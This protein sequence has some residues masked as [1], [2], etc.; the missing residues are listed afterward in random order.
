MRTGE[1]I[2]GR[3]RLKEIAGTGGMGEVWR[4]VDEQECRDVALKRAARGADADSERTH[5]QLQREARNA[6]KLNHPHIV[7]FLDEVIEG[8]ERWLVMEYVPSQSLAQILDQV[9]ALTPPQV[10]Y[11]GAQIASA[12][13]AVHARGIQ[14]R[15]V[16]PGNILVTRGGIAKLTDFGISRSICGD[17]TTESGVVG[18]TVAF[19]ASEVA[20]GDEPTPESDVF[21]L[22]A[23]LFAAVEGTPPF[24]N[25]ENGWRTLRL[26]AEYKLLPT[27]RA[28]PLTPVLSALLQRDPA[29]RPNAAAARE[30]L[31]EL[32]TT[33]TGDGCPLPW[34]VENQ[35]RSW[36][37]RRRALAA[38]VLCLAAP[39]IM[40]GDVVSRSDHPGPA[41]SQPMAFDPR[42]ADPC[43]LTDTAVLARFGPATQEPALG[44][45]NRC[46][47]IV[48]SAKDT[49]VGV[50]VELEPLT[51]PSIGGSRQPAKDGSCVQT[52]QSP[53]PNRI[54]N[55]A[56]IT[57][58]LKS[59][60]R[61][62]NLCA[63]ADAA[64]RYAD[65]VLRRGGIPRRSASFERGS[66]ARVSA[67][68]LLDRGALTRV[69]GTGLSEPEIGF[70][71]WHCH[72]MSTTSQ[73]TVSLFF[74]Q[75]QWLTQAEG[76]RTTIGGLDAHNIPRPEKCDVRVDKGYFDPAGKTVQELLRIEIHG[77]QPLD[78]LCG[79]GGPA[80]ELAAAAVAR[81]P[82]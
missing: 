20:G 77:P 59:G 21:S 48:R 49:V 7:A 64:T 2:V 38:A 58:Q 70:G 68:G 51:G 33:L 74:D 72:W 19:M 25:A 34:P 11:L 16:K 36:R 71:N 50:K 22:G 23:T 78:P 75:D 43:A 35:R 1:L 54:T 26:A 14:H 27:R 79:P 9:S 4:A 41:S 66:L 82:R 61:P 76:R 81:L 67:C 63:I 37:P 46:D 65:T 57:A 73:L 10:T 15:D 32:A 52:L 39:L 62:G 80:E 18:G 44:N 24:G 47:V 30:M 8:P 3:Y 55:R 69:L 5:R 12:L 13:E 31:Q 17:V 45:F 28:G 42:S 56:T 53:G 40:A 29:K 60:T 6:A